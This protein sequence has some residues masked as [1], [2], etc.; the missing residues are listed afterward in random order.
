[1]TASHTFLQIYLISYLPDGE[2]SQFKPD[3]IIL[4]T[5]LLAPRTEAWEVAKGRGLGR[6]K[7]KSLAQESGETKNVWII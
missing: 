3:S 7:K 5:G 6:E 2:M 1:M 4:N